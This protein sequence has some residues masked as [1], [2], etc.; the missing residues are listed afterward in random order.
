MKGLI[1]SLLVAT[2]RFLFHC[3][4]FWASQVTVNRIHTKFRTF[5]CRHFMGGWVK[6]CVRS[7]SLRKRPIMSPVRRVSLKN[8]QLLQGQSLKILPEIIRRVKRRS[9][10]FLPEEVG[11]REETNPSF[12]LQSSYCLRSDTYCT[13]DRRGC[14]RIKANN[15]FKVVSQNKRVF[16]SPKD[17]RSLSKF[18]VKLGVHSGGFWWSLS[19]DSF[20][21][22]KE[23]AA[24]GHY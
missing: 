3:G 4:N 1:V 19:V 23:A 9:E 18:K 16:V 21:C 20:G 12:F 22:T 13:N 24:V 17:I 11:W 14:H 5:S 8:L 7:L 6:S 10:V 15:S 2:I